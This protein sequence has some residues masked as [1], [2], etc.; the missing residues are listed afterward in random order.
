MKMRFSGRLV[1]AI[2]SLGLAWER[3]AHAQ[4]FSVLYNFGTKAGDP[5]EPQVPGIIS[6][7]RDGNLYTTTPSGGSAQEGTVFK[8]TPTG[9]MSVLYDFD[10][11]QGG[12]TG[13][14]LTLVTNGKFYGTVP[15]GGA[16]NRGTLFKITPSGTLTTLYNFTGGDDGGFPDD[17]PIQGTDGN[18]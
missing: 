11:A 16:S 3:P 9:R 2:V 4:T 6:Q 14:G 13:S 10:S 8:I 5:E 17:P 7:G 18:L 12:G 15:A 1:L